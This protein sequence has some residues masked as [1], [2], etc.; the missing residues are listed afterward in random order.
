[1]PWRGVCHDSAT[2]AV[3]R[4]VFWLVESLV[5]IVL[6]ETVKAQWCEQ[7]MVCFL[8][9]SIF[10]GG[11]GGGGGGGG[12][13]G[14]LSALLHFQCCVLFIT[15]LF[16]SP[17]VVLYG[18]IA[19]GFAYGMKAL[20]GPVTQVSCV[21][22]SCVVRYECFAV[23]SYPGEFLPVSYVVRYEDLPRTSYPG[24]CYSRQLCCI[25]WRL[26][27]AQSPRWISYLPVVLYCTKALQGPVT[28]MRCVPVSFIVLYEGLARTSHPGVLC[29]CQ[30]CCMTIKVLQ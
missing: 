17:L 10:T 26:C 20:E 30:L 19:I 23:T 2:T 13:A 11:K 18:G 16:L 12:G 14:W 3:A 8:L 4:L 9:V 5:Q 28:Q 29:T 21:H 6:A 24:E 7:I 27:N 22:V 25:V 1:M 15:L